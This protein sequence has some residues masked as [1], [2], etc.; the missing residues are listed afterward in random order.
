LSQS[1]E[2]LESSFSVSSRTYFRTSQF[3][4]SHERKSPINTAEYSEYEYYKFTLENSELQWNVVIAEEVGN[5]ALVECAG[6]MFDRFFQMVRKRIP[7]SCSAHHLWR[8]HSSDWSGLL[9]SSLHTMTKLVTWRGTRYAVVGC[10]FYFY[11][12][13]NDAPP[14]CLWSNLI[15]ETADYRY[16]WYTAS[17][18]NLM[19]VYCWVSNLTCTCGSLPWKSKKLCHIFW[20][21]YSEKTRRFGTQF[22]VW[23]SWFLCIQ[24]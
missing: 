17:S 12:H 21:N 19:P 11:Q 7:V 23:F 15:G 24:L 4:L 6:L 3:P 1:P 8:I 18:E 9:T 22:I 20:Q 5:S 2:N 16:F 10:M 14:F 13:Q